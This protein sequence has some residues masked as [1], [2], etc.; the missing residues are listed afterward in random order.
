MRPILAGS[1][2]GWLTAM[3]AVFVMVVIVGAGIISADMT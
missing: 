1:G 3:G 2:F